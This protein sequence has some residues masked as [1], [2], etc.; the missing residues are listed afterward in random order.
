MSSCSD[1]FRLIN[2]FLNNPQVCETNT[3]DQETPMPEV[4]VYQNENRDSECKPMFMAQQINDP[5]Y[6]G[7]QHG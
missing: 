7:L 6:G 2:F 5:S 3:T 4:E 1:I